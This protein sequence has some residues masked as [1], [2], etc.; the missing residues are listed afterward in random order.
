[1]D[2]DDIKNRDTFILNI[3][4]Y[5]GSIILDTE[6]SLYKKVSASGSRGLAL[7]VKNDFK[8][9]IAAA[10]QEKFNNLYSNILKKRELSEDFISLTKYF[11]TSKIDLINKI[12]PLCFD[13]S[14]ETP[15][16]KL[17][18]DSLEDYS[19]SL[20]ININETLNEKYEDILKEMITDCNKTRVSDSDIDED[21][22]Q[23]NKTPYKFEVQMS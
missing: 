6:L 19:K 18:S 15:R 23:K 7:L 20:M 11:K 12:A 21:H 5:I 4:K 10:I 3:G 2:S 9:I 16:H 13:V 14:M 1:M 22:I 8:K 17:K